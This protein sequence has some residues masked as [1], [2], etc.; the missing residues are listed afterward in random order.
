MQI[1]K[2]IF[3]GKFSKILS[4]ELFIQHTKYSGEVCSDISY[5]ATKMHVA[6]I[7]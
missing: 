2:A 7:Y 6:G 1:A 5:F 3:L 4:A